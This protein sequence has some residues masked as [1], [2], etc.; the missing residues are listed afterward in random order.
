MREYLSSAHKEHTLWGSQCLTWGKGEER[1]QKPNCVILSLPLYKFGK[2]YTEN[3]FTLREQRSLRSSKDCRGMSNI[4]SRERFSSCCAV[5]YLCYFRY[6]HAH[7]RNHICKN[8]GQEWEG[9]R[10]PAITVWHNTEGTNNHRMSSST[11][12]Y[13]SNKNGNRGLYLQVHCCYQHQMCVLKKEES[14]VVYSY[15]HL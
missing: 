6:Q 10:K 15:R 7:L 3:S 2:A 5:I 8:T 4:F 14:F 9:E 13:F 11:H 12:F 1:L